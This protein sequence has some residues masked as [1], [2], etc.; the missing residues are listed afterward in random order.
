MG[1]HW[2]EGMTSSKTGEWE[3]PRWLYDQ[4]DAEFHFSLDPCATYENAKCSMFYTKDD[5]GLSKDWRG[6]TVFMNPPY[7]R[8]VGKWIKKAY[9]ESRKPATVVVGLLAARTDTAWFHEYVM[10]ARKVF[11]VRGRLRFG[12]ANNSAPF[13]SMAVVWKGGTSE[14]LPQVGPEVSTLRNNG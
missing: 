14:A 7:G 4:L 1:K 10:K 13:P 2:N 11:F 6:E 3:T 8:E 12:G 9:A 5:D